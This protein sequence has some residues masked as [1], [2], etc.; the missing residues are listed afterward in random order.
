MFYQWRIILSFLAQECHWI[1]IRQAASYW[2]INYF[3][4]QSNKQLPHLLAI[5]KI[6]INAFCSAWDKLSKT[7]RLIL[8]Y[9]MSKHAILKAEIG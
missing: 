4:S 8:N 2:I 6:K 5:Y 3:M 1:F 7:Q 9:I